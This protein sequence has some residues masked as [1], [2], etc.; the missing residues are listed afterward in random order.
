MGGGLQPVKDCP[1][2]AYEGL[3]ERYQQLLEVL[4]PFGTLG[5]NGP[6]IKLKR[7]EMDLR[8]HTYRQSTE[9]HLAWLADSA[10][11]VLEPKLLRRLIDVVHYEWTGSVGDVSYCP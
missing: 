4:A 5:K 10:R 2:C 9:T 7:K 8:Y 3:D 11:V 1:P 6:S